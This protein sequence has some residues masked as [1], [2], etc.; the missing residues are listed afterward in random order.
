MEIDKKTEIDSITKKMIIHFPSDLIPVI[1]DYIYAEIILVKIIEKKTILFKLLNLYNAYD[2]FYYHYQNIYYILCTLYTDDYYLYETNDFKNFN[3]VLSR[4]IF[5][6]NT[7]HVIGFTCYNNLVLIVNCSNVF[8]ASLVS[9]F[10]KK[11]S[12]KPRISWT[13]CLYGCSVVNNKLIISMDNKTRISID[14]K[15]VIDNDYVTPIILPFNDIIN[16]YQFTIE[17][18]KN[19]EVVHKYKYFLNIDPYYLLDDYYNI[20]IYYDRRKIK[21]KKPENTDFM[22]MDEGKPFSHTIS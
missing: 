3:I 15:S 14:I 13:H 6:I 4:D 1:I 8:V 20:H 18:D 2:S 11:V 7:T 16:E 9:N 12:I 5:Q 17:C 10:K 21:N 22:L 19:N